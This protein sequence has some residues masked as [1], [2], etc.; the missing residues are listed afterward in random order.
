[1][2]DFSY[3]GCGADV[4]IGKNIDLVL[5]R[6]TCSIPLVERNKQQIVSNLSNTKPIRKNYGKLLKRLGELRIITIFAS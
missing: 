4:S 5:F 1:M 2:T 6:S 3:N